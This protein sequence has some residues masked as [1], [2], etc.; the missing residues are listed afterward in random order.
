ML[1][2]FIPLGI[3]KFIQIKALFTPQKA[4][5]QAF[6]L[7]CTPRK[8]RANEKHQEFFNTSIEEKFTTNNH[9]I[10]T[11]HWQGTGETV[12]LLHGWESNSFRWK[13]LI[14]VLQKE[15]YNVIAID[16]PAQGNSSGKHLNVPLYTTCA[17]D[18]ISIHKPS[19]VI[20]HSL[21]GMTAIYHQL[22]YNNPSIQKIVTLGPPSELSFFIKSFQATLGFSDKFMNKMDNY[23]KERFGFYAKEFSVS[24][25]AKS[26][27]TEGLLILEKKDDLA[28]YKYSKRIADNWKNCELFTVKNIGHSLQSPIIDQKIISFLK[29]EILQESL[30][31]FN[32]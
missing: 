4:I 5:K 31:S 22:K 25:F 1:K 28:P 21:G 2:K 9:Q 27:T 7:F 32:N 12:V 30:L 15:N 13:S 16:A 3:G 29:T 18:I 23:L 26:M 8:G 10:Q 14:Q 20:G 6:N 24:E 19:I 17:Q 11:Y